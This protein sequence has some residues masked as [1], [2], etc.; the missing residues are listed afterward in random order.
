MTVPVASDVRATTR[1]LTRGL[2]LLE[3]ISA[4]HDGATVTELASGSGLDK[5]TVSRLLATLR[6]NGWAHQASDRRYRLAGKALALS[7]DYTNRVDLRALAMPLLAQL[8]DEWQETVHLGQVEG[9][10][11]VYVERLEPARPVRVVSIVGQ[12]MPVACTAMGRAYL[13]AFPVD[14]MRRMVSDLSLVKLTSRT[15]VTR[16]RLLAELHTS[17]LRGYAIDAQESEAEQREQRVGEAGLEQR[18][19]GR[20][21]DADEQRGRDRARSLPAEPGKRCGRRGEKRHF[22]P[23]QDGGRRHISHATCRR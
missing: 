11:V 15:I 8:R 4:A 20:H 12:R 9:D 19:E 13:A 10:V 3:L 16:K 14:E 22:G 1:T 21:R 23:R 17:A 6:D 2:A 7:H 5:G 18:G